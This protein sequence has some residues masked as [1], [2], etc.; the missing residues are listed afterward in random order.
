[1]SLEQRLAEKEDFVRLLTKKIDNMS[2]EA[3]RSE[4]R[5]QAEREKIKKRDEKIRE[6]E[7]QL[8]ATQEVNHAMTRKRNKAQDERRLGEKLERS[9]NLERERQLRLEASN[10]RGKRRFGYSRARRSSE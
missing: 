1:M 7:S 3:K 8:A 5:V 10:L 9:Q 6:L 4:L 2:K